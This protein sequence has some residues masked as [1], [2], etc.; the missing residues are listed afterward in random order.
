MA[1]CAAAFLRFELLY[2]RPSS[3]SISHF[4]SPRTILDEHAASA[5]A[6]KGEVKQ[7]N[8]R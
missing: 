3:R 7:E 4:N 8:D 2:G 6:H 1:A 5:K